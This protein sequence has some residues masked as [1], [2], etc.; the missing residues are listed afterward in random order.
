MVP[1]AYVR[2][3]SRDDRSHTRAKNDCS[4]RAFRSSQYFFDAVGTWVGHS[5]I[6]ISGLSSIVDRIKRSNIIKA[7]NTAHIDW[8]YFWD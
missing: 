7:E 5:S 8:H 6:D 3:K 2:H 1:G 4:I